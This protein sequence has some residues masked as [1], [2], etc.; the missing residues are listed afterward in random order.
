ML[1]TF[2]R[3]AVPLIVASAL[4]MESLD[5]TVL[6]TALP[7]VARDLD[8]NPI[9]LKLAVTSYLLALAVFIPASGW[10]ADRFGAK[11]VFRWAMV[12][13]GLGSVGCAMADSL[14]GLVAARVV[15]GIGGA[16]MTPVGRLLMLRSLPK[17]EYIDAVA[18]FTIPALLGPILGP[19]LGGFIT[20]FFDWRWIFWI[21]IPVAVVALVLI[22]R[23]IPAV[24]ADEKSSFDGRGFLLVGPGLALF[25]TGATVIGLDI[26]SRATALALTATGAALLVAYLAHARRTAEPIIDLALL[27]YP[28]FRAGIY[29][30]LVFRIGVG[31]MPFLLPLLFQL[32][33]GLTAFQSGMLTF[34]AGAGAIAMKTQAAKLLRR[35]GY[36]RV[37][38]V[39]ALVAAAFGVLPAFFT[40]STPA[41]LIVFLFLIGGLSRSLQF[42]AINTIALAEV[43]PS[44]L[45]RATT[46]TAVLQQLSGTIGVSLAAFGLETMQHVSGSP[47]LTAEQFPLVFAGIALV[48]AFAALVFARLP[49][50]A[51]GELLNRTPAEAKP[52]AGV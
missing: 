44:E 48:T 52:D 50:D 34:A 22:T 3:R 4:F 33:F 40:A 39:N 36:R 31:A 16:M 45:T 43:A 37:L 42:T 30:G 27:R 28:T 10:V 9:H 35:Y 5:A 24:A 18:W 26:L 2:R 29:G 12:V 8:V 6:A 49:A 46:F 41:A 21:N 7:A 20:T 17:H 13:F 1:S 15:Q 47:V 19:P 51:G 11:T 23:F 32:G 38:I 14:S 25:L